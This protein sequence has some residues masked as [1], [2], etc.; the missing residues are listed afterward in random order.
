M[1][2]IGVEFKTKLIEVDGKQF[3]LQLWDTAGMPRFKTFTLSYFRR[4]AGIILVYD[5]TSVTSVNNVKNWMHDIEEHA[6]EG[7]KVM[8]V[9]NKSD[10]KKRVV[11]KDIGQTLAKKY[12]VDFIEVSA[13]NGDKVDESFLK[14]VKS[15]KFQMDNKNKEPDSLEAPV[16]LGI[17]PTMVY[18]LGCCGTN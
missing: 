5:V 9:A 7:V 16:K 18:F 2:T 12:G 8:I 13:K 11:S 17:C 4:A 14:I 6:D 3:K 1:A 10:S 15:I